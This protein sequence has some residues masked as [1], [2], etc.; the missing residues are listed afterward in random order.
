MGNL[1]SGLL[2]CLVLGSTA[3]AQDVPAPGLPA[4]V[5]DTN[6][7]ALPTPTVAPEADPALAQ[8]IDPNLT[9]P[10]DATPKPAK[11]KKP[12]AAPASPTIRG[13]AGAIDKTAM[14][15]V[16]HGKQK[17]Q[18]LN[19]TSKTR[20]FIGTKPAILADVKEGENVVAEYRTTK[21]KGAK[22]AITLRFTGGAATA[23][24]ATASETKPSVKPAKKPTKAAAKKKK[25]PANAAP[26][27][28]E[29]TVNPDPT[30]T[31]AAPVVPTPAPQPGLPVPTP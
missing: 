4:P 8:P 5:P 11:V 23:E 24:K 14:T 3:F 1:R 21:D 26:T 25:T 28:L 27:P 22:E 30:A 12:A 20:I 31:N 15:I 17:D 13:T 6:A 9:I 29:G 18:T 16:V 10:A 2:A 19:I 7:P